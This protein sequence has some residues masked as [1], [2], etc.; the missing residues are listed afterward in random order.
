MGLLADLNKGF[1]GLT[2]AVY[3]SVNKGRVTSYFYFFM[4]GFGGR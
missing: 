2:S 3:F 1:L 4:I